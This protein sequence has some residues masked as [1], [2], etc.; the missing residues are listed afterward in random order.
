MPEARRFLNESR[1]AYVRR[2]H[3]ESELRLLNSLAWSDK[4]LQT[5]CTPALTTSDATRSR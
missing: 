5:H 1:Q 3:L 2:D 4:R